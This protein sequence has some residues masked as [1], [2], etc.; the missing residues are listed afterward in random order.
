MR[1]L[2]RASTLLL[3]LCPVM[4]TAAAA[5]AQVPPPPKC[6]VRAV[7]ITTTSGLDWPRSRDRSEQQQS[8]RNMVAA[9]RA[10]HL[11]T[12][13]FQ[14]RARGDAYYRSAYEPWAE[15]LTG[16]L[17]KDPGWDPLGFLLKEAHA[18]GLEVHAWFNVYKVRGPARPAPSSPQHPAR[19]HPDWIVPYE[20]EGWFDPGRPEVH[21]YLLQVAIDLLRHYDLDG[22]HFDFLRYPGRDFPD[23]ETYRRYG[24]GINR[25]D[26]RRA[27]IDRFV[28]AVYDS[29]TALKPLLK[30]GSAPVG[31]F[32]GGNGNNGWG[33]FSNYFQDSQ[34][35][36]RDGKED[37]LAPQIYWDIGES[38]GDPDFTTLARS[39]SENA[40]GRQMYAGVAAYKPEVLEQIPEQIDVTR[41]LGMAGQAFFRYDHVRDTAVFGGRYAT[42]ANIPPMPWKDPLAPNPPGTVAVT[43]SGPG[44]FS[45]EWT[46]PPRAADGD[47]ATSY[48]VYRWTS[49]AIPFDDPHSLVAIVP[50][51]RTFY[52]DTVSSPEGVRYYFAVAAL[53]RANN[54]STPATTSVSVRELVELRGRLSSTTSLATLLP[55]DSP[56][57][58]LIAFALSAGTDITLEL[59]GAPPLDSTYAVLAGGKRFAGTHVVGIPAGRFSPGRYVV[60]LTTGRDRLEQPL[61]LP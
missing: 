55:V 40:A 20:G 41:R 39:W 53:D 51:G 58:P 13:F 60:R 17:G 57:P 12:I 56:S 35:W 45:I 1:F 31:V 32:K 47:G 50:E 61:N 52:A 27:N 43:E 54:E 10:A 6:E 29:A 34:G 7:W 11:N 5:R 22:M 30:V 2:R 15:N 44:L 26:W 38:P 14:A 24:A 33:A 59:R 16:T 8:L 23:D 42:L 28:A 46:A 18:A 37:Y 25:D 36:L 19:A 21:D 4:F 9:I 48:N 3:A 49:A